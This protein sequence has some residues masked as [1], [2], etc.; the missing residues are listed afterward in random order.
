MIDLRAVIAAMVILVA[1]ASALIYV[2]DSKTCVSKW[3]HSG[4]KSEFGLFKGCMV[5]QKDGTWIPA[6]NYRTL[7]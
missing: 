6:D 2:I 4:M 7:N 5:Q 3:Q 1:A